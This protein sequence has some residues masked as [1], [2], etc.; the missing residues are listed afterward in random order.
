MPRAQ[1]AASRLTRVRVEGL[2]KIIPTLPPA[3]DPRNAAGS[4]FAR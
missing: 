2:S 3:S 4:R 1:A